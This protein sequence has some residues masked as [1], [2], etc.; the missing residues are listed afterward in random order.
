MG[1][2]SAT[3]RSLIIIRADRRCEYCKLSQTGQ[4][5]TFHIDH[6]HPVA[7][8]GITDEKNLA[9][10]CV[11][12]SL[13][14]AAKQTAIDPQTAEETPLFN[15]RIQ[16]WSEHFRWDVAILVGLTPIGRATIATLKMN[17]SLILAIR[18]EE[19]IRG[20]HPYLDV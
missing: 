13:H 6:V 16:K 10:A 19:A 14:K 5:A 20:R 3:L 4:E 8:G 12:C 9:L 2:I 18:E 7:A 17:R 1:D 15:P 11:S